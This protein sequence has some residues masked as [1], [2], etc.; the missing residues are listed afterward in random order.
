MRSFLRSGAS[1]T[2]DTTE[3]RTHL[4]LAHLLGMQLADYS[5]SFR[6]R[7][8]NRYLP[9]G[10]TIDQHRVGVTTEIL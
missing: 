2:R 3:N 9:P 6:C 7:R 8:R 1:V 4:A 5:N 10:V